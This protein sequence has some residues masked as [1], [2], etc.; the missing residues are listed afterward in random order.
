MVRSRAQNLRKKVIRATVF[1]A[2]A[3]KEI[4]AFEHSSK[5][6]GEVMQASYE[7]IGLY[8]ARPAL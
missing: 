8:K 5:C 7:L 4:R 1:R 3:K 6:G 2:R